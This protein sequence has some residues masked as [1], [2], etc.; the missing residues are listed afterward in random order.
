MDDIMKTNCI[1]CQSVI[2]FKACSEVFGF[3]IGGTGPTICSDQCLA[4]KREE[5]AKEVSKNVF[6]KMLEV[7][8]DCYKGV[9]MEDFDEMALRH[10]NTWPKTKTVTPVK[11]MIKRYCRDKYWNITL[12]SGDYGNG[13]TRLS[14]YILACLAY[15]GIYHVKNPTNIQEAGYWSALDIVKKLKTETF[16][17]KQYQL[18]K[19]YRTQV[20]LI[21]DLGQ[22]EKRD[23]GDIAGILKVREENQRKTIITTNLSPSEMDERYTGR[24]ASRIANGV[25]DVIGGDYRKGEN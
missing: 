1:V 7:M 9:K 12:A 17:S 2:D 19:F 23:S 14:L 6:S 10:V 15:K 21:D 3:N 20:L 24:I 5:I 16:D 18:N 4:Q 11:D 22:E 8:P 13:K 25:F